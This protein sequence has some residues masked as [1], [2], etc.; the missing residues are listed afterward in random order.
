MTNCS[1]RPAKVTTSEKACFSLL[2]GMHDSGLP[3]CTPRPLPAPRLRAESKFRRSPMGSAWASPPL[4]LPPRRPRG[5]IWAVRADRTVSGQRRAPNAR[6]YL[7]AG[8][9]RVHKGVGRG[10]GESAWALPPLL[11]RPQCAAA[12]APRPPPAPPLDFPRCL[13]LWTS[14]SSSH[15]PVGSSPAA[16]SG[17]ESF[18]LEQAVSLPALARLMVALLTTRAGGI[19]GRADQPR[20]I[21]RPV[22]RR[23]KP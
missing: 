21:L 13:V 9:V 16:A 8:R 17:D 12:H 5:G 18:S 3:H 19:A 15:R 4:P 2:L 22:E 11:R 10:W 14:R 1:M 6:R 20:R 23:P 7:A